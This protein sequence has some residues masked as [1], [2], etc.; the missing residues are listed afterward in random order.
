LCAL[1]LDETE[2]DAAVNTLEAFVGAV[3]AQR[4]KEISELDAYG[5]IQAAANIIKMLSEA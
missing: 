1:K 3:E 5:L 2:S 4:G